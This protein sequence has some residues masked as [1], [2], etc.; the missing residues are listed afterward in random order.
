MVINKI[1][2]PNPLLFTL[3]SYYLQNHTDAII[4]DMPDGTAIVDESRIPEPKIVV[5]EGRF[6]APRD[7]QRQTVRMELLG[8]TQ[9]LELIKQTRAGNCAEYTTLD[10]VLVAKAAGLA[11]NPQLDEY[12]ANNPRLNLDTLETDFV[13]PFLL[14]SQEHH[15]EQPTQLADV[16]NLAGKVTDPYE[17][18]TKANSVLLFR[19]SLSPQLFQFKPEDQISDENGVQR[20]KLNEIAAIFIG[21]EGHATSLLKLS[22]KYLHID[23]YFNQNIVKS[24]SEDEATS[25]LRDAIRQPGSIVTI[26]PLSTK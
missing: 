17:S 15:T 1:I 21:N 12:L 24:I 10:T 18:L 2:K 8:N 5:P 20:M 9:Q 19:D 6:E 26:N 14:N 25:L 11:V 16:N 23:P 22:D 7:Y 4:L 3:K 13:L